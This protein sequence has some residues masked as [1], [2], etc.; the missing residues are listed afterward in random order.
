MVNNFSGM[1]TWN[2][3]LRVMPMRVMPMRVM[4]MRVMPVRARMSGV[5]REVHLKVTWQK[6]MI[7]MKEMK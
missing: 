2:L 6:M 1:L 4:P 3:T 7:S 5:V